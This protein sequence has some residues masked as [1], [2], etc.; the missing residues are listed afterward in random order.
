MTLKK[1]DIVD[2]IAERNGFTKKQSTEIL[3]TF[4]EIIKST[5][6]SGEDVLFPGLESFACKI[7][8]CARDE[9]PQLES[10]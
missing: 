8:V 6:A 3:Q 5:L 1:A 4:I 2:L 10:H 7:K 9:T